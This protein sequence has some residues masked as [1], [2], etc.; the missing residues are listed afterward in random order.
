[1]TRHLVAAVI[2]LLLAGLLGSDLPAQTITG[3]PP[4][5]EECA[6][7][8]SALANGARDGSGWERLPA[9]GA[10]GGTAMAGAFRAARQET[11]AGY[12]EAL[13]AGMSSIRDPAVLSASIEVMRDDA[14]SSRARATAVLIAYSQYQDG[15]APSIGT[16][17]G[18]VISGRDPHRC[19]LVPTSHVGWQSQS[20]LP[21]DYLQQLASALD[22]VSKSST[23]PGVVR[24]FARCARRSMSDDVPLTVPSSFIRLSYTCD[25][26]FRVRNQGDE[27]V[28]VSWQVEGTSN[29]GDLAV[30]PQGEVP[31]T[32]DVQGLTQLYYQG[33]LLQSKAN[34]GTPCSS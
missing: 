16:S 23:A 2:A 17:F 3:P 12:L 21:A 32:A 8:A 29:R 6:A 10:A 13:Y 30:P 4:S 27:W 5:A 28:D 31:F 34:P 26:E 18:D 11:N 15:L 22:Q 20:P 33:S 19:P 9:C 1:M 14:A 7:A 24:R 25:N